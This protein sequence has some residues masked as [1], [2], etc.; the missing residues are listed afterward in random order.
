M[1]NRIKVLSII[2]GR[3]VTGPVRPL[4]DLE[5]HLRRAHSHLIERTFLVL[6]RGQ[7]PSGSPSNSLVHSLREGGCRYQMAWEE[8]LFDLS[9]VGSISRAVAELRPDIVETHGYRL[10][11]MM[12]LQRRVNSRHDGPRWIAF[13]HGY[14]RESL[15]VRIYN[16]LDRISLP[17]ADR[18][19]TVCR[20]FGETLV[21]RG[22]SRDIIRI[23]P[24]AISPRARLD[25]TTVTSYRTQLGLTPD[26]MLI[27]AAGR[28][29][30][31]KGHRALM[32]ACRILADDSKLPN[33]HMVIAGDGPERRNLLRHAYDLSGRVTFA[34]HLPDV[35]PLLNSAQLF[36]LPSLSEGSPIVLLEAMSAA[37][38]I[39]AT[40]VGGIPDTI[41][42]GVSG[43]LVPPGDPFELSSAMRRLLTD[44]PLAVSLGSAAWDAA[45]LN[46]PASYLCRLMPV[47]TEVLQ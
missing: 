31:E 43:V 9:M 22:V 21:R 14:T 23:V 35:W 28:L 29:S 5:Q 44:A 38:P 13:Q 4:L 37:L 1:A 2:E 25:G 18:V 32:D 46:S 17:Q 10:H 24:N 34:G 30:K 36:V 26:T 11:F 19:V 20:P 7:Q 16:Q 42:D 41:H 27:V 6:L 33:W 40:N 47:Y 45:N 39:V 3:Y 12:Y 15:R 8:S